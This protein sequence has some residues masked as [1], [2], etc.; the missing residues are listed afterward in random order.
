MFKISRLEV[1]GIEPFS[2]PYEFKFGP[3]FTLIRGGNGAGKTT[4]LEA[5]ALLGHCSVMGHRHENG[6]PYALNKD[7]TCYV[8]Y[9]II[10]GKCYFDGDGKIGSIAKEW[11]KLTRDRQYVLITMQI[12]HTS[13][14][15]RGDLKA[16]LKD[17]NI[18]ETK[19]KI[20]GK[21]SEVLFL[22][23][24]M[25]FSRPKQKSSESEQLK[26]LIGEVLQKAKVISDP[27]NTTEVIEA[28]MEVKEKAKPKYEPTERS[29]HLSI[30]PDLPPFIC[31]F[32]TDMYHYG[33][34]LDIRESPKHLA[35]ELS[36]LV[37]DRLN[38]N[39][40]KQDWYT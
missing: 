29:K 32:N 19:W 14:Q 30:Q 9:T 35:D 21:E 22:K 39:Q 2:T 5:L 23:R 10:L 38:L 6:D 33:L 37:K 16:D 18:L 15:I 13:D 36:H 4:V 1:K 7:R 27:K 8:E 3:Y 28:I 17:E 25:E 12:F 26:T 40:C 34:G 11:R 20:A 31:Y 24:L